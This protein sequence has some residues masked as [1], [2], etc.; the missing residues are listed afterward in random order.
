MSPISEAYRKL[1][2]NL[3]Y[4]ESERA[5]KLLMV[6]SA[7]AKEGKSTTAVNLA[8]VYAQAGQRVLLLDCDMR[9]PTVHKTFALS[10]RNGLSQVLSGQ[11]EWVDAVQPTR[12]KNLQVLTSGPIPPNPSELLDATRMDGLLEQ[13]R[14]RYDM[15][16]IDTPPVLAVSDAQIMATRCD[17]VLLVVNARGAKRRE[18]IKAR[19]ALLLVQARIVGVALNGTPPKEGYGYYEYSEQK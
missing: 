2:T 7:S 11:S 10:N 17:G 18:A 9:K 13:L 14:E 12:I 3:K 16:L 15:V 6:T 1:R 5:L 19:E 4:S 8:T